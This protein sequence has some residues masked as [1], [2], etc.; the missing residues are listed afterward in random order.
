MSDL[1]LWWSPTFVRSLEKIII[2]K[3]SFCISWSLISSETVLYQIHKINWILHS[4]RTKMVQSV[5]Q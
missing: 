4:I 3:F 1:G 5:L 2:G